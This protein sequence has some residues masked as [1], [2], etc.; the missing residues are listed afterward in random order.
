MNEARHVSQVKHGIITFRGARIKCTVR[1]IS[2]SGASLEVTQSIDI[3]NQFVLV[4]EN[5]QHRC[6]VVWRKER[7]VGVAFY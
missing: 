3:P 6:A 1:S 5:K 7:R 4:A 2:F